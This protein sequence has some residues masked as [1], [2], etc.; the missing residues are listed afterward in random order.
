MATVSF[1]WIGTQEHG[2]CKWLR[3]SGEEEKKNKCTDWRRDKSLAL[4]SGFYIKL[5]FSFSVLGVITADLQTLL[6]SSTFKY[7]PQLTHLISTDESGQERW[8][9]SV[10][11]NLSRMLFFS[12]KSSRSDALVSLLLLFVSQ[13]NHHLTIFHWSLDDYD[14]LCPFIHSFIHRIQGCVWM[15]W[16]LEVVSENQKSQSCSYF[17]HD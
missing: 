17:T 3:K 10:T 8:F 12:S 2:D 6:L 5:Y 15:M 7:S 11:F 14:E 13:C 4:S 9:T 16:K 1:T